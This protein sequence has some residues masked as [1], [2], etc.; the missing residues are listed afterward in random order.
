M[1]AIY[2][3]GSERSGSNLLRILLGNHSQVSAP[4]APHFCDVFSKRFKYYLPLGE[5]KRVEL[6]T[7]I[8][9]Y[10]NHPFNDWNFFFDTEKMI[11]TYR[12]ESFIDFMH[13]A[14][15]EKALKEGKANYFAKDNHNHKYA[16]GI[17]KDIPG[18]KFIYLYRDPRDHVASWLRTPIHLHTPFK[19]ISKWTR[20]QEACLQ[21]HRF[22]NI[23][24]HFIKYEDLVADTSRVMADLLK[25][26]FLDTE[27]SC[28]STRKD[29]EDAAKH[30]LWKNINK[31]IKK[32]NYGKFRDVLFGKNLELVETIAKSMMEELGYNLETNAQ[33]RVNNQFLFQI[34]EKLKDRISREK[35]Y[36]FLENEMKILRDKNKFVKSLFLKFES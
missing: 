15:A 30:P 8:E 5:Q 26:L 20:E 19:A 14:Y 11:K 9:R 13:A 21:L 29:N 16:L 4:I 22:Y 34:T 33:W 32:D 24:M 17:L 12:L 25:F 6:L 7:D 36:S 10:I 2:L 18:V 3:L 35:H 1:Q 27:V 31:P 23:D 28:F